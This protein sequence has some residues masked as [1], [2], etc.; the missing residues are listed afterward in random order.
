[1]AF[2]ETA[3][4]IFRSVANALERPS[5]NVGERGIALAFPGPN[6]LP[7]NEPGGQVTNNA[8]YRLVGEDN[9][10]KGVMFLCRCGA[11]NAFLFG[12]YNLNRE[13]EAEHHCQAGCVSVIQKLNKQG[14]LINYE[15]VRHVRHDDKGN[16]IAVGAPFSLLDCLPNRGKGMSETERDKC[17]AT[18]P[19]WRFGRP[20]QPQ[21]PFRLINDDDLAVAWD[22]D[23]RAERATDINNGLW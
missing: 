10:D 2:R 6:L 23:K 21:S 13:L 14:E 7:A 9:R 17:Y 1:M 16:P 5:V 15:Q 11:S 20:S 8:F 18:L 3:A 12:K 4:N 19:T 22:G